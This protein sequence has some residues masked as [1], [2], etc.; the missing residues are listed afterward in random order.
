MS[1]YDSLSKIHNNRDLLQRLDTVGRLRKKET[2]RS[3]SESGA[4][5]N[6]NIGNAG[7]E[8]ECRLLV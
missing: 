5:V 4:V 2:T 7:Q 8:A 6:V 1:N 3:V